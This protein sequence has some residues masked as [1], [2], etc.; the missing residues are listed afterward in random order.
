[1]ATLEFKTLTRSEA[2][3]ALHSLTSEFFT[4]KFVK[5]TANEHGEHEVRTM[6]CRK[7]VQKHLAGGERAYDFEAHDLVG[8]YSMDAKGYR[9]VPIEGIIEIR[10]SGEILAVAP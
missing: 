8:V 1:M 9:T 7:N 4:V 10:T 5:R 2:A 6:N 3:S